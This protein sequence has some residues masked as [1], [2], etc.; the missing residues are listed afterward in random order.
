MVLRKKFLRLFAKI[1]RAGSKSLEEKPRPRFSPKKM[2]RFQNQTLAALRRRQPGHGANDRSVAVAPQHGP[3]DPQRIKKGNC[4]FRRTAVKIERHLALDS[5]RVPISRAVG[6][7]YPELVL[8][9]L[10][11][12]IEGINPVSPAPVEKNQRL[13]PSKLAIVDCD[14]TQ[15]RRVG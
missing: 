12:P 3:L 5:G 2:E 15:I 7:Q 10:N 6:D 1:F 13:P 11:L 14:G 8:K 9:R 4:F